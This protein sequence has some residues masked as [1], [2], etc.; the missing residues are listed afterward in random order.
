MLVSKPCPLGSDREVSTARSGTK[1]V[2]RDD[3]GEN[4]DRVGLVMFEFVFK[5]E[6]FLRR[7]EKSS[8]FA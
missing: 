3:V 7:K 5:N 4:A 8:T 2:S 1:F 6:N